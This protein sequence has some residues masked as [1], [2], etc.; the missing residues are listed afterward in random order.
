M[1]ACQQ[2]SGSIQSAWGS[3]IISIIAIKIEYSGLNT[4]SEF[5]LLPKGLKDGPIEKLYI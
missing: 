3:I 5:Q 2:S 1:S 4:I